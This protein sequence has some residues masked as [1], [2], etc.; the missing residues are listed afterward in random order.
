MTRTPWTDLN[1]AGA[2]VAGGVGRRFGSDK[3]LAVSSSGE[4]HLER[5]WRA[6]EPFEPRWVIAGTAER[7][8][9]L[10]E[11]LSGT[12]LAAALHPDDTP[13]SGPMGGLST[14]LRL[15]N[16]AGV[17]AVALLAVDLPNLEGGYWSWLLAQAAASAEGATAPALVPRDPEGRWH[18]LAGLYRVALHEAAQGAVASERASLQRFLEEVGAHAVSVP[19]AMERV[20]HNVNTP[21]DALRA[22]EL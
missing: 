5:A 18:P 4:R 22:H 20:L 9:A 17:E 12:P 3:A 13:G 16:E 21:A 7:C 14:A 10:R 19:P 8:S 11:A 6:L 1:I 15:G 2:L